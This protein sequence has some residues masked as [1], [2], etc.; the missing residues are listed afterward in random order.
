MKNNYI[1]RM[2]Q[3]YIDDVQKALT[4]DYGYV[5]SLAVPNLVN[6]SNNFLPSSSVLAVTNNKAMESSIKDITKISGQKPLI[7]R[8]KKA[9]S[10]F[11][12]REGNAIGL[13]VT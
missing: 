13:M 7:T 1:P 10:N 11:K 8:A 12:I 6:N 3:T 4:A 9:I 2:K 5:N